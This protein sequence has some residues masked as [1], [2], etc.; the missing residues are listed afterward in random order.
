[1]L[2]D[3]TYTEDP[4][5]AEGASYEVGST[6]HGEVLEGGVNSALTLHSESAS[7]MGNSS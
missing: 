1:M 7:R 4:N 2:S 5:F 6:V 3:L